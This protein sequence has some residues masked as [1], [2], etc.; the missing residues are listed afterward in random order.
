[1]SNLLFPRDSGKMRKLAFP[2][3]TLTTLTAC[4]QSDGLGSHWSFESPHSPG[5]DAEQ[6][7]RLNGRLG[8]QPNDTIASAQPFVDETLPRFGPN[9][10]EASGARNTSLTPTDATTHDAS[11]YI[12]GDYT[13]VPTTEVGPNGD[14]TSQNQSHLEALLAA[15]DVRKRGVRPHPSETTRFVTPTVP[16]SSD[17]SWADNGATDWLNDT[18]EQRQALQ[19]ADQT[20]Y[21][22]E[23]AP[24]EPTPSELTPS[25]LTPSELRQL[26]AFSTAPSD[27]PSDLPNLEAAP[28]ANLDTNIGGPDALTGAMRQLEP[29]ADSAVLPPA[30]DAS[31][32]GVS[33]PQFSPNTTPGVKVIPEAPSSVV[34]DRI[35]ENKANPVQQ[36]RLSQTKGL[37]S[38]SKAKA[39]LQHTPQ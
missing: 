29:T 6:L 7:A 11:G 20:A 33:E 9:V 35:P 27:I 8:V 31:T 16:Y 2:L 37:T 24:F 10:A 21:I 30:P 15:A 28:D 17:Q 1:M 25:E 32:M 18:Y 14:P 19:Q 39:I 5:Q 13:T 34:L 3:M 4:S 12:E 38:A 26:P 23:P 36:I 22:P